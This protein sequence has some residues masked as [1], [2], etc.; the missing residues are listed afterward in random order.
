M[1][2]RLSTALSLLIL[3]DGGSWALGAVPTL[4]YAFT[5]HA[6]PTL[7]GIRLLGGPFERLGLEV[8]IVAGIMFVVVSALK[9]LAAYWIWNTRRDGAILELILLG[10]ST[11]F[12]YGFALP[13]GP[14]EGVAELVLIAVMW[15]GL[16]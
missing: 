1:R 7:W 16:S 12:W 6:L 5:H 11:V 4:H 13:L 15:K 9:L 8:L 3:F 14:M 2:T 10:V